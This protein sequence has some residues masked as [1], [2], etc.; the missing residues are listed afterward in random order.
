MPAAPP[1][2]PPVLTE[3]ER[4]QRL[5]QLGQMLDGAEQLLAATDL[6]DARARW[7]ALRREWT[8]LVARPRPGRRDDGPVEG[9]SRRGSTRAKPELRE[10]R[11]RQQH[12]NLSRLQQL[13]DQL[14]KLAQ[15][16]QG[17]IA[18]RRARPARGAR[19]ARCARARCRPARI[20]RRSSA[21]LKSDPVRRCSPACRTCARP[22]SGS[23][24]RTP[25]CRNP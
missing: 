16:E 24:G 7:M 4:A 5:A 10:A 6:P 17:G 25:A 21:R 19:G 8:A 12:E 18:R 13:C 22:T 15:S 20:S 11:T 9:R 1:T 14:E 23:A 2:P 3:E